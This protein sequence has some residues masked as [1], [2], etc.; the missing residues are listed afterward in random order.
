MVRSTVLDNFQNYS[1]ID[2]YLRRLCQIAMVRPHPKFGPN[3]CQLSTVYTVAVLYVSWINVLRVTLE[4][5]YPF[6][7]Q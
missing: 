7:L 6:D 1:L 5:N 3:P 4:H 2:I